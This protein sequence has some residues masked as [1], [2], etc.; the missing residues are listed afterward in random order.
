MYIYYLRDSQNDLVDLIGE[1]EREGF[2]VEIFSLGC[3][4]IEERVCGCGGEGQ[5]GSNE[6][7]LVGR[8]VD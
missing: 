6:V 4:L 1:E 7:G 8:I 2:L 5:T 3:E